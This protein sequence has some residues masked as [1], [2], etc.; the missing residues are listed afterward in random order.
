MRRNTR[1]EKVLR[2][3]AL[4]LATAIAATSAPVAVLADEPADP[5]ATGVTATPLTPA[6]QNPGQ[7]SEPERT[8]EEIAAILYPEIF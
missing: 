3:M 7:A 1:N 8:V 5:E 6:T 2:A 4:G